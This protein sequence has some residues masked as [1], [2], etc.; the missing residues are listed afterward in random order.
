MEAGGGGASCMYIV[1]GLTRQ[2]PRRGTAA[3]WLTVFVRQHDARREK[4]RERPVCLGVWGVMVLREGR[5]RTARLGC[6][7]RT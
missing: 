4:E 5:S 3:G 2:T 6:V 7:F 1:D